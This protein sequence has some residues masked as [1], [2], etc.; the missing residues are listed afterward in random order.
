VKQLAKENAV[1]IA[2]VEP[3]MH[4]VQRADTGRAFLKV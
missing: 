2:P 4:N 3:R 1:M